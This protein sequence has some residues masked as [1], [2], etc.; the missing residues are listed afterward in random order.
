[1]KAGGFSPRRLSA[2]QQF[3]KDTII[4]LAQAQVE[5]DESPASP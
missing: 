5:F 4:L 3:V 1:M 2:V